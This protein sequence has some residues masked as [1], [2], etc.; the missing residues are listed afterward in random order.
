MSDEIAHAEDCF[1]LAARFGG[2]PVGPG[3]LPTH[4]APPATDL[5]SAVR[6]ANIEGCVG[7]TISAICAEHALASA[8]DVEARRVLGKIVRDESRHAELAFRFVAWAIERGG[9]AV[10]SAAW[11]EFTRAHRASQSSAEP[12]PLQEKDSD[13]FRACGRISATERRRITERAWSEVLLP[14]AEALFARAPRS[15]A[16]A[17]ATAKM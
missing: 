2:N 7:E 13:L 11:E 4:D 15:E 12:D 5:A 8:I 9:E 3:A 14:C 16:G 1:A 10:R 17:D 6:A